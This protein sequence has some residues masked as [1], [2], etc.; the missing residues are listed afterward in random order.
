MP[1]VLPFFK[2]ADFKILKGLKFKRFKKRV[3]R[4]EKQHEFC[5][6]CNF[7]ASNSGALNLERLKF[8]SAL[9][10]GR[11]K[12]WIPW[13]LSALKFWRFEIWAH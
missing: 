9:N 1:R 11:L 6:L 13:N 3:E 2:I 12:F 8:F 5:T 7:Y 4:F 10:F